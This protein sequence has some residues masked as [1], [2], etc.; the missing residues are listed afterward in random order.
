MVQSR[1]CSRCGKEREEDAFPF[2][3]RRSEGRQT[4]CKPCAASVRSA[5]YYGRNTKKC[6]ER[7]LAW[8]TKNRERSRE[9]RRVW[10]E[11]NAEKLREQD[12]HRARNTSPEQRERRRLASARFY[13]KNRHAVLEAQRARVAASP[14]KNRERARAWAK[15]NPERAA[16]RTAS[17]RT[18]NPE[19]LRAM[20]RIYRQTRRARARA[21]GRPE[22]AHVEAL[23]RETACTYCEKPFDL[24]VRARWLTVDHIISLARGGT[25]ASENLVAACYG[26]NRSKGSKMLSEWKKNPRPGWTPVLVAG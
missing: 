13:T 3:R 6:N 25:N 16:A 20:R 15:K 14:D 5:A 12:R 23:L 8:T 22:R 10:R 11:A 2:F 19:T 21:A 4:V 7:S 24:A 1:M 18:N 9:T 26:C 17:W